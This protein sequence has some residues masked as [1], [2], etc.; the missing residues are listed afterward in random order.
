MPLITTILYAWITAICF[1]RIFIVQN[2]PLDVWNTYD[3]S[4]F[5]IETHSQYL[6]LKEN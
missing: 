5:S 2:Y 6:S 1:G 4:G 3:I